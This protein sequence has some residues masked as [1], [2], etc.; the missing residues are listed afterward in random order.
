MEMGK[1]VLQYMI[2]QGLG[3]TAKVYYTTTAFIMTSKDLR[4]M[5]REKI[6]TPVEEC[7]GIEWTK[8]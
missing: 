4:V 7:T 8:A 1:F 2:S 5:E 6:E 3:S